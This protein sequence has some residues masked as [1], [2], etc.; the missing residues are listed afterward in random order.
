MYAHGRGELR[1]GQ[2]GNVQYQDRNK[3][4]NMSFRRQGEAGEGG[5]WGQQDSKRFRM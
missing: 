2:G 3:D 4:S 1:V 5:A